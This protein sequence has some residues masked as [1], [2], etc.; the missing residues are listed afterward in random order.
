VP[1]DIE[2]VRQ[3]DPAL[4]RAWRESLRR[5]LGPAMASEWAVTGFSRDGYYV[6]RRQED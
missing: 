4:A 2:A 6:L 3:D 5:V 1:A